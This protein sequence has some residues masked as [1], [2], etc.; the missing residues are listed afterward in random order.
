LVSPEVEYGDLHATTDGGCASTRGIGIVA[1]WEGDAEEL[2]GKYDAVNATLDN[3]NLTSGLVFQWLCKR[4]GGICLTG[5]WR[6]RE[7]CEAYTHGAFHEA[8]RSAGM[9]P[10]R[11]QL[12]D[13]YN[14]MD[15]RGVHV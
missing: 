7:E 13:V 15:G 14:A 8:L 10:P 12:Y 3:A 4:A 6:T 11:V 1:H 9:P 2:L 5:H